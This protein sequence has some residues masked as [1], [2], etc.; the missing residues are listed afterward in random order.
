MLKSVVFI[1]TS[2]RCKEL[3]TS[4]LDFVAFFLMGTGVTILV[5]LRFRT[6]L[7]YHTVKRK[8]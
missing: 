1:N 4:L 5:R 6:A 8:M 7:F 3:L 2:F